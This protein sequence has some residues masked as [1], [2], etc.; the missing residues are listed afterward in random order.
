MDRKGVILGKNRFI[1][2]VTL[3]FSVW[4]A[5]LARGAVIV[6]FVEE[7]FNLPI[8][9][10]LV[11]FFQ[12]GVIWTRFRDPTNRQNKGQKRRKIRI[13][14]EFA[15]LGRVPVAGKKKMKA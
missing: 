12:F 14:A 2:V 3:L 4:E 8:L 6:S 5:D 11:E 1:G 7:Y 10:E 9:K 13:F 15:N